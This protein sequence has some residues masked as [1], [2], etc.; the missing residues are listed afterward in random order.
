MFPL[1][2]QWSDRLYEAL[3][4]NAHSFSCSVSWA[5]F[6]FIRLRLNSDDSFYTS[7]HQ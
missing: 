4:S 1:L 3:E 5:L 7:E 6:F 2:H